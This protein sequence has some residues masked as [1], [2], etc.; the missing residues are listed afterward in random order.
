[1]IVM[2]V[3]REIGEDGEELAGSRKQVSNATL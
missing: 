3:V 1:M 2:V